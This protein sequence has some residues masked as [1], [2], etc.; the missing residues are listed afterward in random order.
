MASRKDP[1]VKPQEWWK[2]M[3]P[4]GKREYWKKARA[5]ALIRIHKIIKGDE[6]Y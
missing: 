1:Y 6:R 3:K 4:W 5:K 2:H